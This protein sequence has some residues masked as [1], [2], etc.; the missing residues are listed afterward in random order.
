MSAAGPHVSPWRRLVEFV[1]QAGRAKLVYMGWIGGK[2]A[3]KPTSDFALQPDMTT[4]EAAGV[5][6]VENRGID[7]GGWLQAQRCTGAAQD[8]RRCKAREPA[9]RCTGIEVV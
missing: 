3:Q 7:V 9:S 5:R 8:D 1:E 6:V 4:R 2:P